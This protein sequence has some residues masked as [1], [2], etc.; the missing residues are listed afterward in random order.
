M[1]STAVCLTTAAVIVVIEYAALILPFHTAMFTPTVQCNGYTTYYSALF[2]SN[3]WDC[4]GN[5]RPDNEMDAPVPTPEAE[6]FDS[7]TGE[8]P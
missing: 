3:L 6:D 4:D 7:N 1:N 8:Y 5:R 2:G